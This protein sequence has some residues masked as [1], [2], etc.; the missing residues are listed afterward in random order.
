MLVHNYSNYRGNFEAYTGN[1]ATGDVHHG[2]PKAYAL[3]SIFEAAS[4]DVNDGQ[5]LFGIPFFRHT[6]KA[7]KGIYTNNSYTGM[8]W[9]KVWSEL[10]EHA[11]LNGINLNK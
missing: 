11:K 6:I 7:G 10:F 8:T 1:S 5:Y 3:R 4:I 9:N 2:F